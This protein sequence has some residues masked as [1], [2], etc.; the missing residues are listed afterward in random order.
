[1]ARDHAEGPTGR[2]SVRAA[3]VRVIE[4]IERF[5][6]KL[7]ELPLERRKVFADRAV[8]VPESWIAERIA[9]LHPERSRRNP[10][11]VLVEPDGGIGEGRGLNV[12]ISAE[13]PELVSAARADTRVVDIVAHRERRPGLR[14]EHA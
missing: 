14:L 13:V 12:R 4:D 5:E 3:P 11:R 6:A 2:I 7:Q 9:R 8:H 1:L 10:K